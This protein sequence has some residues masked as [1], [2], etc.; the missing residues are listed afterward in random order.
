[1]GGVFR[2]EYSTS[3]SNLEAGR[4]TRTPDQRFGQTKDACT[5]PAP[6]FRFGRAVTG[7]RPSTTYFYRLCGYDDAPGTTRGCTNISMFVTDDPPG[8]LQPIRVSGPD[9]VAGGRPIKLQGYNTQV[10]GGWN[11][12]L[13]QPSAASAFQAAAAIKSAKTMGANLARVNLMLFDFVRRGDNGQLEVVPERMQALANLLQNAE[14]N[15][16][17]LVL[18]GAN[19]WVKSEAPAWYDAMTYRERWTVQQFFWREVA[20]VT[21][22][23]PA[24]FA[25]ELVNEP[26][27]SANP[28]TPWYQ[29]EMG[30][31]TF[32]ALIARGVPLFQQVGVGREW[33]I[34]MRDAVKQSDPDALTSVGSLAFINSPFG[35]SVQAEVLDVMSVHTY[36]VGDDVATQLNVAKAFGSSGKPMYIGETSLFRTNTAS[37]EAYLRAVA[38]Y[39]DGIVSFFAGV[40]PDEKNVVTMAEAIEDAN[41]RH[42]MSMRDVVLTG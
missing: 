36:V 42:F 17:Y 32:T 4:G 13:R 16:M 9:L 28:D 14:A 15:R 33:L 7:L 5:T 23:S 41:A 37:Q 20:K 19:V 18:V 22:D 25:Y 38:P 2:F 1:M 3:K 27:I 30:G 21:K 6:M 35:V 12:Y 11:Q 39:S 10:D 34:M 31:Y 24:V 26:S 40:H 29:H 8:A